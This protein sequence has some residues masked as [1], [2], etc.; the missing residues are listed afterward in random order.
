[1]LIH[2]NRVFL[3]SALVHLKGLAQ[4]HRFGS[5]GLVGAIRS[6][7]SIH[8]AEHFSMLGSLLGYGLSLSRGSLE[9]LDAITNYG[10]FN[11]AVAIFGY[12]SFAY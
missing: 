8:V 5:F 7:G 4:F 2:F 3:S 1:M 9:K 11:D 10:S 6:H 12:G